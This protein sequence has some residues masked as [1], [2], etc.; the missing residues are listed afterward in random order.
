MWHPLLCILPSF[1][2]FCWGNHSVTNGD[3]CGTPMKRFLCKSVPRR[4]TKTRFIRHRNRK[5]RWVNRGMPKHLKWKFSPR[6]GACAAWCLQSCLLPISAETKQSF[7]K[8]QHTAGV[9]VNTLRYINIKFILTKC[10]VSMIVCTKYWEWTFKHIHLF[11]SE[12]LSLHWKY[13]WES[14][15]HFKRSR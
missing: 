4:N 10:V 15:I 1:T 5:G 3:F 7:L 11:K 6:G 14:I 13:H 9:G 2:T 8:Q 12:I